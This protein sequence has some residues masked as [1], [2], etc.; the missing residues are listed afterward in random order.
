[1]NRNIWVE[2]PASSGMSSPLVPRNYRVEFPAATRDHSV[3]FISALAAKRYARAFSQQNHAL[4]LVWSFSAAMYVARY[5]G[6]R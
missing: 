3:C 1:M 5:D 6:R 4:V 2:Q